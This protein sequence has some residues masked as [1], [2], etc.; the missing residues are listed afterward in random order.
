MGEGEGGGGGA[1]GGGALR[2]RSPRPYP[3]PSRGGEQGA[4]S[5]PRRLFLY[6]SGKLRDLL[7]RMLIDI[8]TGYEGEFDF[9]ARA[10]GPEITYLLASAPRAGRTH[11]SHV[12]W[13]TRSL[14]APLEY[15][16]FDPLGPYG[17]AATSPSLQQQL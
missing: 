2:R 16:T 4:R 17:F 11:F 12:L 6:T 8:D 1:G 7:V 3:S 10:Q 14:G 9:P 5:N 13:P 15:L